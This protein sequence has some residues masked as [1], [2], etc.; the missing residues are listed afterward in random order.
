MGEGAG[1]RDEAEQLARRWGRARSARSA[2]PPTMAS[3]WA[4]TGPAGRGASG[5]RADHGDHRD[6]RMTSQ[7]Q[8]VEDRRRAGPRP[9]GWRPPATRP[10]ACTLVHRSASRR[11]GDGLGH[12]GPPGEALRAAAGPRPQ[13]GEVGAVRVPAPP[14][15][16]PQQGQRRPPRAAAVGL[17]PRAASGR[18]SQVSCR[19]GS[20]TQVAPLARS[21]GQQLGLGRGER[22]RAAR[23]PGRRRCAGG[24]ARPAR[25]MSSAVAGRTSASWS[26]SSA[27]PSRLVRVDVDA[28]AG[29]QAELVAAWRR[30]TAMLAAAETAHSKLAVGPSPRCAAGPGV[31]HDAWPGSPRAAPRGAPSARRYG[32][33]SASAPGAGRRR[34]GTRGWR[35]RPR[36]ARR[37]T[38][39][40]CRRCRRTRRRSA[41][42][43]QRDDLR[44]DGQPVDGGEGAGQLAQ[45]ER[46]GQPDHQRADLVPAAHARRA[47]CTRPSWPGA[48]PSRSSTSRGRLPSAYGSRSS[49]S[50]VPVGS[51]DRFCSRSIT[52]ALA[53]TGTRCGLH[54]PGAGQP[55]AGSAPR[56]RRPAAAAPASRTAT[57]SRSLLAEHQRGEPGRRRRGGEEGPPAGGQPS[58]RLQHAHRPRGRAAAVSGCAVGWPARVGSARWCSG[59][60]DRPDQVGDDRVGGRAGPAGRR[61]WG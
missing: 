49:S 56:R 30:C 51:R 44:D 12:R 20:A 1:G 23:P 35:C 55:V 42:R 13:R 2:A 19:S 45:P 27:S 60:R 24:P 22:A 14:A 25:P 58:Q 43:R 3:T 26:S 8:R 34:G 7:V 38:G 59:D 10:S 28:V 18:S 40:G 11:S 17:R 31:E 33:S 46:V 5:G 37:P 53:P 61:R 48:P 9:A 57:R 41:H 39:P 15:S 21:R 50:S 16:R 36:R 54:R 4:Q 29:D 47:P 52:R 6:R 32:R